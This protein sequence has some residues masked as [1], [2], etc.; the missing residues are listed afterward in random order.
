[1]IQVPPYLKAGDTIGMVCP[2]GYMPA[3]KT[4][5][6]VETLN[7][8][9]YQVKMGVSI[10]G[11]SENYFSGSDDVRKADLQ[12]MLDDPSIKAILFGRGGYG[13]SRIIDQ[14][15]FEKFIQ[16]PKWLIGFSDITVI[17]QHVYKNYNIAGLHAPM[18]AAFNFGGWESE[19]VLS[20]KAALS[21][22]P[23]CYTI[24]SHEWNRKGMAVGPLVGGNLSLVAHMIGSSSE[25]D[26]KGHILF[27]EDLGEQL[28]HIDRMM[29]QLRRAGLL[30]E[31]AGI[32]FGGFTEMENTERPFGKS[33]EELL[34]DHVAPFDYPVCFDFPVSHGEGNRALKIGVEWKLT[35]DEKVEL[36]EMM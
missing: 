3:S 24:P 14:L 31:L 33:L 6:C 17:L 13:T 34:F 23:S 36:K 4:V 12:Q 30:K 35:V 18:A 7:A 22:T 28:Y 27:L 16:H 15:N 26:L 9:G 5:S 19:N 8:W 2:A 10:G 25:L 32:V 21:G 29:L 20:L 11:S 1:M